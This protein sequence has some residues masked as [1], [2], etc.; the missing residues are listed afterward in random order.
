[1]SG[2]NGRILGS[3]C[4]QFLILGVGLNEVAMATEEPKYETT[5]KKSGYEIRSYGPTLVAET[6]V[7]AEF[8]GA[9][10]QAFRILADYIFGN[11][12]KKQKIAMTAPVSQ[13]ATSEKIA[14]TAPVNQVKSRAGFLVQ[15]T[16]PGAYTLETLP[17]PID[18]RVKIRE[19]A[20]RKVAVLRYTGSWSEKR[21]QEELAKLRELLKQDGLQG[22]GEPTFA[23]FNS[24][25]QVWFLR[26]NEIWIDLEPANGSK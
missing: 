2:I 12:R 21:F 25:F 26:R 5:S 6:E 24:P 8:E 18:E 20:A 11:N 17:A 23:R 9:G 4:I 19:L 22:S 3:A 13:I 10:N 16:M 7:H 1:M 14:M 15:F